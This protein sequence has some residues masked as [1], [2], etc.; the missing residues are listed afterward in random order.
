MAA[1]DGCHTL[2]ATLSRRPSNSARRPAP[3]TRRRRPNI[4]GGRATALP[5]FRFG[6]AS[7]DCA[8]SWPAAL[9]FPSGVEGAFTGELHG[10]AP[11]ALL[12]L[13]TCSVG[14]GACG[15][16]VV[17]PIGGSEN[18]AALRSNN[19]AI[20]RQRLRPTLRQM[21]KE[22]PLPRMRP[23]GVDRC[24]GCGLHIGA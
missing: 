6:R 10:A 19:G 8:R 18:A 4:T 2:A 3:I 22:R 17:E 9:P 12:S 21:W 11:F 13:P 16:A 15:Y 23:R 1:L 14:K 7:T 24:E 20:A 5:Y